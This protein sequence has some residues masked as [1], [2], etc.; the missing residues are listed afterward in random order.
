MNGAIESTL[1]PGMKK[2]EP[3]SRLGGILARKRGYHNSRDSLPSTDYSVREFRADK[4]G[5]A[6][7]GSA[8]DWTFPDAQRGDYRTIAKYSKRLMAAGKAKD[9]RTIYMREFFGN[10]DSDAYVEGYDFS[11]E[12]DST[13]DSSH[14][15]HIH[16]SIHRAYI[17]NVAAMNAILSILAGELLADYYVRLGIKPPEKVTGVAKVELKVGSRGPLVK[18]LQSRLNAIFPAYSRLK[19]DGIY[20]DKTANVLKE[21]QRRTGLKPDGIVGNTTKAMLKRYG[22]TL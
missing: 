15:W 17:N 2:L 3:G 14:L 9:P 16:I 8:I 20:G 18:H 19:E 21:F 10:C 13:S 4:E 1:W 12:T 11:K 5:P 7:L 6:N 22:I